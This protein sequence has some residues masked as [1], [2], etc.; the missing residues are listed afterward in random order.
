M[1][2]RLSAGERFEGMEQGLAAVGL[3]NMLPPA[4]RERGGTVDEAAV[5]V[6]GAG[7][8]GVVEGLG[9]VL[10]SPGGSEEKVGEGVEVGEDDGEEEE[11]G[12]EG[13]EGEVEED[14]ECDEKD[15]EEEE[16]HEG[17]QEPS[18]GCTS[19]FMS[20]LGHPVSSRC[21]FR[22]RRPSRGT[23]TSM[24]SAAT[25]PHAHAHAHSVQYQVCC[26][27]GRTVQAIASRRTLSPLGYRGRVGVRWLVR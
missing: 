15:E 6:Y 10:P 9:A 20:S 22:F 21:P 25:T 27:T 24:S 11:D 16:G 26:H 23:S 4:R 17:S 1:G 8:A 19:G 2:V 7:G 3:L 18:S 14:E 5:S 13:E 12:A